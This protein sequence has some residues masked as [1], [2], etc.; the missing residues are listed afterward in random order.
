MLTTVS[1]RQINSQEVFLQCVA[2]EWRRA[3]RS[4]R[5][6]LLLIFDD[7]NKLSPF[8]ASEFAE[9]A[10]ELFRDTDIIGWY[11]TD[12]ALGV[13]CIEFGNLS[14]D[15]A[16]FV[17]LQKVQAQLLSGPRGETSGIKLTIHVLPPYTHAEPWGKSEIEFAERVW[18]TTP[19]ESR[20]IQILK[21]AFDI[22]GSGLLLIFLSPTL[23]AI[24]LGVRLTSRGSAVYRQARAGLAGRRFD[25]YKFRTMYAGSDS[26]LHVEY[27]TKFISGTAEPQ[28]DDNGNSLYKQTQDPRVTPFGRF[29]RRTSLDELPQL[30][31]V[32]RGDMSLV[33]PRPPIPYEVECYELWHRRRVFE[34]KP[35]LTGLWQVRGRSRCSFAEMVR[36]DLQHSKPHSLSLYLRVLWETPR[37][38]IGGGGAQ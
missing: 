17:I 5:P 34:M 18:G 28:L 22:A 4:N 33:G 35:G 29:L 38:V 7:I 10:G 3:E 25:L 31:N 15:E 19:R 23:V 20:A 12:Q 9:L 32:L 16:R 8:R 11:K 13:V 26:R 37:A 27:V 30:W 2:R 14:I 6:S 1:T 24:A 36:L 21:R